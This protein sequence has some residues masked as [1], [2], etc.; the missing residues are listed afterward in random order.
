MGR[1][2]EKVSSYSKNQ[3]CKEKFRLKIKR[4]SKF[5]DTKDVVT[6]TLKP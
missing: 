3:T 1:G 6:G 2:I 4:L 5:L